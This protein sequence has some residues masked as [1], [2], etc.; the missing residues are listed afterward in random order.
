MEAI[1]DSK[2]WQASHYP[3]VAL[4]TS[5]VLIDVR[6]SWREPLSPKQLLKT[7]KKEHLGHV[8]Q[9]LIHLLMICIF[10]GRQIPGLYDLYVL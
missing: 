6:G 8:R 7:N 5:T 9:I 10:Q 2:S 3:P 1:R 4:S